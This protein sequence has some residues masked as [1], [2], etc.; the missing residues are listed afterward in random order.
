MY[1]CHVGSWVQSSRE[2]S[3]GTMATFESQE[4]ECAF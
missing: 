4:H 3:F 1:G 2:K